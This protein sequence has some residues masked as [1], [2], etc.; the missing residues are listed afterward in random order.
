MRGGREGKKLLNNKHKI[1][2][3]EADECGRLTKNK[4]LKKKLTFYFI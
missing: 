3:N 1:Q 2:T 4:V